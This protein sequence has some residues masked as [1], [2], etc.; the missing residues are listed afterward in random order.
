MDGSLSPYRSRPSRKTPAAAWLGPLGDQLG[1][2]VTVNL[3]AFHGKLYGNWWNWWKIDGNWWEIDGKL[4]EIDGKLMGN[5]WEPLMKVHGIF[6]TNG[7]NGFMETY[8][9]LRHLAVIEPEDLW[10]LW[11]DFWPP[12]QFKKK[13]LP[14]KRRN[15]CIFCNSWVWLKFYGETMEK[16]PKSHGYPWV[17]NMF[18]YEKITRHPGY[19]GSLNPT[20]LQDLPSTK[21]R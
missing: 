16:P 13:A 19:L 3:V 17:M 21:R 6:L 8:G 12:P 10:H 1:W 9:N 20:K 4:M 5:W 2:P 18:S 7:F 14:I 11:V 15:I